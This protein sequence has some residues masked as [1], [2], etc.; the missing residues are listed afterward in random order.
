MATPYHTHMGHGGIRR[1]QLGREEIGKK[2]IGQS[3]ME[4]DVDDALAFGV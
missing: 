4:E 2:R 3:S 1:K